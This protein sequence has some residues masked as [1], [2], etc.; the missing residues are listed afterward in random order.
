[1]AKA[2]KEN[3]EEQREFG[4]FKKL[5]PKEYRKM[6]E[7]MGI[8][9]YEDLI[10]LSIMLGIDPDKMQKYSE[11]HGEEDIPSM[12]EVMFD[13]DNP[14]GDISRFLN[15]M[16]EENTNDFDEEYPFALP[17]KK[18]FEDKPSQAYRIRI[19]LDRAPVPIWREIEVPSN[20][21]LEF[22]AFVIIEAMGWDNEHLHQFVQNGKIYQS[23]P[24]IKS[25]NGGGI[26]PQFN[27]F[28]S[29][30]YP[31]SEILKKKDDCIL[32]E[33]DFG[34]SWNHDVC[35]KGIREYKEGEEP[36][37]TIIEGKGVCPPEDCGGVR[38]YAELL[39][40]SGKKRK[41]ENDKEQLQ[42]Y[43][44]Y[45]DYDPNYFDIDYVKENLCCLWE[46]VL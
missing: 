17:E 4:E 31:L 41:S 15:Q 1:M 40:L 29:N 2:N 36:A 28:S 34:D 10:G 21:S 39:K 16:T 42:W 32:F 20:I 27:V 13:D 8:N 25:M 44:I 14:V 23:D 11:E 33:Y 9:S 35:L 19:K 43:G 37:L 38:G 7:E 45:K 3:K 24:C 22:F 6:L 30:G 18:I 5:L 46:E 12:E 26:A